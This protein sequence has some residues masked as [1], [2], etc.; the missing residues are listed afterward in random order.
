VILLMYVVMALWLFVV[1]IL[2]V[3]L[4]VASGV[5]LDVLPFVTGGI[6]LVALLIVI[7]A[8][9]GAVRARIASRSRQGGARR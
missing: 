5:A 1:S 8:A 9:V 4:S 2:R 3:A 6:G 7:P